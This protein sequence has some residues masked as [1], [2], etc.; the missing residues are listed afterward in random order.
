MSELKLTDSSSTSSFDALINKKKLTNVETAEALRIVVRRLKQTNENELSLQ[1]QNAELGQRIDRLEGL[2]LDSP[3]EGGGVRVGLARSL[4]AT[5]QEM[6]HV[7]GK[8]SKVFLSNQTIRQ[9]FPWIGK[10]LGLSEEDVTKMYASIHDQL[11]EEGDAAAVAWPKAQEIGER[12][13]RCAGCALWK[14]APAIEAPGVDMT[15]GC[16]QKAVQVKCPRCGHLHGLP[17]LPMD[18][19]GECVKCKTS[20][21]REVELPDDRGTRTMCQQF[22]PDTGKLREAL[23][24]A[25]IPQNLIDQIAPLP[26]AAAASS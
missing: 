5:Q 14:D 10:Q 11:K 23:A 15:A 6:T 18:I 4:Q 20:L 16:T 17:V 21:M 25:K 2:I 24:T 1:K 12:Q 13:Y 8:L 26:N 22:K 19:K 7:G 9:M 3:K